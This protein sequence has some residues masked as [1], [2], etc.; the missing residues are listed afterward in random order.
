MAVSV[1]MDPVL[2]HELERAA[3]RQGI[4]LSCQAHVLRQR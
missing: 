4:I 1:R 2:E 3:A